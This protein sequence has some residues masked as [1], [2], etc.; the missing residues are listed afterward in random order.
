MGM[1]SVEGSRGCKTRGE[2]VA[3]HLGAGI[4]VGQGLAHG[5]HEH[6]R[7]GCLWSV[8]LLLSLLV[9]VL[10]ESRTSVL[11]RVDGCMR[12]EAGE[13]EEYRR[14]AGGSGGIGGISSTRRTRTE[15]CEEIGILRLQRY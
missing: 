12:G 15:T 7:G 4:L 1:P 11:P 14:A 8:L 3:L 2:L 6:D 9:R 13:R 10:V 5:L